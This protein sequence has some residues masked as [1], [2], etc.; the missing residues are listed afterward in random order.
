MAEMKNEQTGVSSRCF[1]GEPRVTPGMEGKSF[2]GVCDS[3]EF[4]ILLFE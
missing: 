3:G 2:G 4:L 1:W